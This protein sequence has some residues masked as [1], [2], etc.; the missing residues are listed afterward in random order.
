MARES[1]QIITRKHQARQERERIQTRNI[2]IATATI[3]AVVIIL[4][5]Y[6]IVN[7]LILKPNQPVASVNNEKISLREFQSRV[8][9]DRNFIVCDYFLFFVFSYLLLWVVSL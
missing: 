1:K 9:Y 6:G 3:F 4:I 2:L 8:R 7:E 5:G